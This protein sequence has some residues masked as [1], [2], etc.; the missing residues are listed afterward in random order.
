MA[1][2]PQSISPQKRPTLTH[3]HDISANSENVAW[4]TFFASVNAEA[5]KKAQWLKKS[6]LYRQPNVTEF[7]NHSTLI[8]LQARTLNEDSLGKG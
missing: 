5:L 1:L 6:I 8:L 7:L 3:V 4:F 2:P